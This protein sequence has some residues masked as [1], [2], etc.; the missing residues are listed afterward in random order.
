MRTSH[1]VRRVLAAAVCAAAL[2]ASGQ[3]APAARIDVAGIK[4]EQNINLGGQELVLN[5]AGIRYR[6]IFKV[7]TA[8][9]YLGAK[10]NTAEA[11]LAAPGAKR[12][13]LVMLRAIDANDFGKILSAGIEKNAS[14]E[15]FIAVLPAIVRM[16]EASASYKQL[17]PGDTLTVDYVP[18][19]GMSLYVKGKLEAGPYKD[20]NTFSAMAKI[21]LGKSPADYLLKDALLGIQ[22]APG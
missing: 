14:R 9:L 16:G 13:H 2:S 11:V 18:G 22:K 19:T 6:A 3:P 20:P 8:G 5:G 12:I 21:W 7:Y 10:A 4:Y 17:L 1:P 15:D